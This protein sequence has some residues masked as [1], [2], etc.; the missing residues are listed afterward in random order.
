[1]DDLH[2]LTIARIRTAARKKRWSANRL[3][4]FAG[5]G[6]GYLSEVLAGKKSPTLR[7]LGKLAGALEVPVSSLLPEE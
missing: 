5:L 6:R 4:D 7:T 3:A 1:M 2:R